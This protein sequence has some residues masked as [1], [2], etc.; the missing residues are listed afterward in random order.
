[1]DSKIDAAR[2]YFTAPGSV[3]SL[4]QTQIE[5]LDLP[6]QKKFSDTLQRLRS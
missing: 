2:S 6:Q 1:M 3:R 5:Q 4:L